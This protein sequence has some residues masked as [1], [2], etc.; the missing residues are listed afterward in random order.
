MQFNKKN[1]CNDYCRS[2][3]DPN[4]EILEAAQGND[5]AIEVYKEFHASINDAKQ[6]V[7][8][9]LILDFHGQVMTIINC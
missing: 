3:M 4:R 7:K 1:N 8:R 9:G 2:R 6:R 5:L